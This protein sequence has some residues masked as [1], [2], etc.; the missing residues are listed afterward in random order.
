METKR[1]LE[2]IIDLLICKIKRVLSR[3][4]QTREIFTRAT[5]RVAY[6]RSEYRLSGAGTTRNIETQGGFCRQNQGGL[7]HG[8]GGA[9]FNERRKMHTQHSAPVGRHQT[10]AP[11]SI[12]ENSVPSQDEHLSVPSFDSLFAEYRPLVYS[13]GLRLLGNPQDAEDVTQEVFTKVWKHLADFTH[14]SSLK[15]W[16]YRIAVNTCIDHGRKPWKRMDGQSAG[17]ATGVGEILISPQFVIEETAE[18]RLLAKEKAAAL[19]Q[20]VSRLRPHLKD[21]FVLKEL[22][23]MSYDEISSLLGLSMGTIS[24][25]LNRAKKALQESLGTLM[26]GPALDGA[27]A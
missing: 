25:R 17:S 27:G 26:R 16:I 1:Q 21:V 12:M 9:R 14:R 4:R 5:C 20:A 18:R 7:P 3:A 8:A 24:S 13:V 2:S 6:G 15:T 22:E 19:D 23:E 10:G 11:V